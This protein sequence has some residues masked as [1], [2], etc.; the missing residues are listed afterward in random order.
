MKSADE[1]RIEFLKLRSKTLAKGS[2]KLIK[3]STTT[4]VK[5]S[6]T[7]DKSSK[8]HAKMAKN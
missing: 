2:D 7:L 3:L 4:L 1:A 8:S 5:I 6:K